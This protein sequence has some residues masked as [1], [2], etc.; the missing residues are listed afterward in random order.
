MKIIPNVQAKLLMYERAQTQLA[1]PSLL[2]KLS[3]ASLLELLSWDYPFI[4]N[5]QRFLLQYTV[6]GEA[7]WQCCY[8]RQ[9]TDRLPKLT[10]QRSMGSQQLNRRPQIAGLPP[11]IQ[12]GMGEWG[13]G[14]DLCR[15]RP[16]GLLSGVGNSLAFA[17][18]GRCG[19]LTS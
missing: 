18:A 6:S 4:S 2:V 1:R 3:A 5:D 8:K 7:H 14:Q 19:L 9:R 16:F 17:V 12:R 13:P 11:R 10:P 15:D